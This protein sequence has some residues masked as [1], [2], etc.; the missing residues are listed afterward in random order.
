MFLTEPESEDAMIVRKGFNCLS[1]SKKVENLRGKLGPR[2]NWDNLNGNHGQTSPKAG[3]PKYA[4][5][6]EKES[7]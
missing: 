5:S 7:I 2:M 3:F 6:N 4:D 1:C